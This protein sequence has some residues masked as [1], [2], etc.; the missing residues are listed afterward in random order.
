MENGLMPKAFCPIWKYYQT[1]FGQDER[2]NIADS[3]LLININ[4][5]MASALQ[6]STRKLL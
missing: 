5:Q 1:M 4:V 2:S 3:F 6:L